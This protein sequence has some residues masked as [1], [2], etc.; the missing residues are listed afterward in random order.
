MRASTLYICLLLLVVAVFVSLPLIKVPITTAARGSIR[1]ADENTAVISLVAGRVVKSNL[2][3]NNQ[4]VQQGDTLLVVTTEGLQNKQSNQNQLLGEIKAQVSDLNH[5]LAGR[6]NQISTGQYRQ[7]LYAMQGKMAEVE[8]QL[9]LSERERDRNK[10][11]FERRVISQAEY[12]KSHYAYEQ[13]RKQFQSIPIQQAAIWQGKKQELEQRLTTMQGDIQDL[14]IESQNYVVT[15]AATGRLT[16]FK[17]LQAG[18]QVVQGQ[19]LGDLSPDHDLIAECL[20]LPK[21]I[22]FIHPGQAVRLQMDTYNYNQWGMVEAVVL[23]I[24]P[25]VSVADQAEPFFK[26]RCQLKQDVLTLR[27]GYQAKIGKG[28]SFVARFYLLDRTLWQLLFDRVDDWFNP[29]LG[30]TSSNK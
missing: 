17:G 21:D 24:D 20:V 28:N 13:I 3:R 4:L 19:H 18:G 25:N 5:L 1:A 12:D 23:D 14:S 7:E 29:A 16:N 11:L 6:Y 30:N 26:V 9:N 27:N 22:G 15:A 8:T 2:S 10:Q